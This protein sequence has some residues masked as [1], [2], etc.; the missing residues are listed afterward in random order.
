MV[1]MS[2]GLVMVLV[3][4]IAILGSLSMLTAQA[5][6]APTTTEPVDN[7]QY[8]TTECFFGQEG[9][10]AEDPALP[11]QAI[12]FFSLVGLSFVYVF[13]SIRIEKIRIQK[14]MDRSLYPT[15]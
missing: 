2:R 8:E 6:E 9:A 14:E 12:I 5:Q 13:N 11:R 7:E 15:Y 4:N 3:I 1:T 10:P